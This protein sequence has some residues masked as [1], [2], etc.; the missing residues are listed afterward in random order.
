LFQERFRFA[1]KA[2]GGG[3]GGGWRVRKRGETPDRGGSFNGGRD[4]VAKTNRPV[5]DGR[6]F[7]HGDGPDTR[8]ILASGIHAIVVFTTARRP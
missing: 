7:M 5:E 2:K 1:G 8:Y 3:G 4:L 6:A